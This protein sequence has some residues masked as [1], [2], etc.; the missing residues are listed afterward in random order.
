MT[1][2]DLEIA[3]GLLL[4]SERDWAAYELGLL[5][6]Q[7]SYHEHNHPDTASFWEVEKTRAAKEYISE[8]IVSITK[9]NRAELEPSGNN[10]QSPA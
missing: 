2:E 6:S 4:V 7:H 8:V 3:T 5:V 1:N 10:N 9:G